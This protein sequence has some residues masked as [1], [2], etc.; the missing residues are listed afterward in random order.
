VLFE[1]QLKVALKE[2][3]KTMPKNI[4]FCA[5]G[6]WNGPGVDEDHDGVPDITNV[7]K[8]FLMLDGENT[9]G[10]IRLKDEQEK[11]LAEAGTP[12]QV[13]KYLHGVGDSSNPIMKLL[14]GA[15]G[16]GL[17]ARIVRGYT[18]ISR[19]YV[20][21]DNIFIVGFSRGAY[22]ARALGGLICS[23][24]LLDPATFDLDDKGLAYSLGTASWRSY[25]TK[26]AQKQADDTKREGLFAMLGKLPGFARLPLKPAE[27][28]VPA[29]IKAVAVWDT[30]GSLGVPLF[31]EKGDQLDVF[32]FADIDL[33]SKV[34]HGIHALSLDEI[35]GNFPPTLWNART[36]VVQFVFPG[37]HADVG[38]G[39]PGA[40]SRLSDISLLWMADRLKNLGV[41]FGAPPKDIRPDPLGRSHEPWKEGVFAKLPT[42]IRFRPP[43]P[44]SLVAH[45]SV[46]D[47]MAGSLYRPPNWP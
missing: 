42:R 43:A 46:N 27:D 8:L 9:W 5:D 12:I 10:T 14:G 44:H 47:R 19:N 4:I 21:G 3:E 29:P 41:R 45:P 31:D 20:A 36:N 18:F 39:Y 33:S 38:G 28:T 6:T 37:A 11:M 15:F 25:R 23:E 34:E 17:I 22:T 2:G 16:A 30:V 7:L 13:A 32:R 24:G 1:P 35:R 26:A 40:E